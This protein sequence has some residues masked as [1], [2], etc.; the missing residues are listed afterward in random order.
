MPRKKLPPKRTRHEFTIR[1]LTLTPVADEVL[2]QL[3][4]E[5]SDELGWKVSGSAVAR[6]LLLHAKQQGP[7]WARVMLFPL[8]ERELES[9]VV[10][11]NRKK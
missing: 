5:A 1:S 7:E 3:G 6:A 8:I 2:H 9:G 4:E 10:W 11:G